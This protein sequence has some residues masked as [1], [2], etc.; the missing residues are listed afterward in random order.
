MENQTVVKKTSVKTVI[1]WLIIGIVLGGIGYSYA[2]K[3][4]YPKQAA[5]PVNSGLTQDEQNKILGDVSKLII[6]PG[7]ETPSMAV[8]DDAKSFAKD[9]PFGKDAINGDIL[10]Y[11]VKNQQAVIYSPSRN[12]IVNKGPV[13]VQNATQQASSTASTATASTATSSKKK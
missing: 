5:N 10:L 2:M 12:I 1:A 7:D 4:A 8:I 9:F 6:L 3:Y 13:F 11:Y